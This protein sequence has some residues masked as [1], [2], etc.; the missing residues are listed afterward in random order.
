MRSLKEI[1]KE[2]DDA[3]MAR[4]TSKEFKLDLKDDYEDTRG[5]VSGM[6]TVD[7]VVLTASFNKK[8]YICWHDTPLRPSLT[9]EQEKEICDYVWERN[10]QRM[11]KALAEQISRLQEEMEGID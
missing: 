11:K 6:I 3:L 9:V 4:L 1:S 8:G 10:R 2:Y 7:D 5:Y